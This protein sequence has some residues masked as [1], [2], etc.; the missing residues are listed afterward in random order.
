MR[1]SLTLL[2]FVLSLLL[3]ACS[4]SESVLQF[5]KPEKG[6]LKKVASGKI[7]YYN[8]PAITL[9]SEKF[10]INKTNHD[11]VSFENYLYGQF[12]KTLGE[13]SVSVKLVKQNGTVPSELLD[14]LSIM[15]YDYKKLT[16]FLESSKCNYVM[17]IKSVDF[18][19][20]TNNS[21]NK[22]QIFKDYNIPSTDVDQM[23]LMAAMKIDV[24]DVAAKRKVL[25]IAPY[26]KSSMMPRPGY[27]TYK[28]YAGTAVENFVNYLSGKVNT[29][30]KELSTLLYISPGFNP[31]KIKAGKIGLI[32]NNQATVKEYKDAFKSEF[33]DSGKFYQKV[34][35]S[36]SQLLKN[37]YPNMSLSSL[38]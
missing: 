13:Q 12:A 2:L 33:P 15:N 18:K 29:D 26:E 11:S 22:K 5:I 9:Q 7:A 21:A 27:D 8:P 37:N 23:G 25:S 35:D 14:S 31:D 4:S 3:S 1:H 6:D 30:E 17:I 38:Q 34:C 32:V 19:I 20:W 16:D 24:W 36:F 28:E 10:D